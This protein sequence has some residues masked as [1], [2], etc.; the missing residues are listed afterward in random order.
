MSATANIITANHKSL[1]QKAFGYMLLRLAQWKIEADER[2]HAP[3]DLA[4]FNEKINDIGTLVG[5]RQLF[6]V[7]SA[8][9]KK[10][11]LLTVFNN[12]YFDFI[13]LF[14]K[15]LVEMLNQPLLIT[16]KNVSFDAN[17]ISVGTFQD[18]I[19]LRNGNL[20][21]ILKDEIGQ[22]NFTS[23]GENA[24]LQTIKVCEDI[25]HSIDVLKTHYYDFIEQKLDILAGKYMNL[26]SLRQYRDMNRRERRPVPVS[27]ARLRSIDTLYNKGIKVT[28]PNET[29]PA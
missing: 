25:D 11:G 20:N 21:A 24:V 27:Q 18:L 28:N 5:I 7:I 14:E 16:G 15:D 13:G 22:I 2:K 4:C 10:D 19:D 29:V 26:F 12:F 6:F 17:K 1:K 9:G 23:E 3:V 8:N